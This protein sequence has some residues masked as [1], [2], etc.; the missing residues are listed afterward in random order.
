L[1]DFKKNAKRLIFYEGLYFTFD[2]RVQNSLASMFI[3]RPNKSS[4]EGG[5]DG[6][7]PG[8]GWPEG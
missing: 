5:E 8:E 4:K 6:F 7:S 2:Q 1:A 3:H